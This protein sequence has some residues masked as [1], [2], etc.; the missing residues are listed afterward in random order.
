M[1]WRFLYQANIAVQPQGVNSCTEVYA[2]WQTYNTKYI[3]KKNAEN[4]QKIATHFIIEYLPHLVCNPKF[5][6][7]DIFIWTP[8]N[9]Y[10]TSNTNCSSD[11]TRP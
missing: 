7:T 11:S 6:N 4:S 10:M 2:L 5:Q 1:F 9:I 3:A 8:K